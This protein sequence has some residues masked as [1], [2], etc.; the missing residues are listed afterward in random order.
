MNYPKRGLTN[1]IHSYVAQDDP[2]IAVT[3]AVCG[4]TAA[5]IV[6]GKFSLDDGMA[7]SFASEPPVALDADLLIAVPTAPTA[8]R[9]DQLIEVAM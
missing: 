4:A 9:V 2:L 8:N 1:P 3:A 5:S 7:F 6:L